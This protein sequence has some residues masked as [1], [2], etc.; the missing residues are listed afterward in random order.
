MCK[1]GRQV[2]PVT[3]D[4]ET[5]TLTWRGQTYTDLKHTA[6]CKAEFVATRNGVTA[7]LCTSTKGVAGLT[8]GDT[9]ELDCQ[10]PGNPSPQAYREWLKGRN[11]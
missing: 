9:K 7:T 11:R 8:I 4:E 3:V 6:N 5:Y 2:Y 1:V 10:M